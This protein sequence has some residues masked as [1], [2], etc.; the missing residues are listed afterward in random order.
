MTNKSKYIVMFGADVIH[1]AKW[2]TSSNADI[3]H[4]G[5]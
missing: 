4:S 2:L 1:L 5:K 3:I